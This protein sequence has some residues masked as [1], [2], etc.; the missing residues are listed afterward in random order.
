L[1][2]VILA[3]AGSYYGSDYEDT[4]LLA[5]VNGVPLVQS[6]IEWVSDINRDAYTNVLLLRE[7][8][9]RLCIRDIAMLAN[10]QIHIHEIDVETKGALCS[11]MLLS[12]HLVTGEPLLLLNANIAL[13]IPVSTITDYFSTG[14]GS[15]G[16]VT[17][18]SLHPRWSFVKTKSDLS[19]TEAAEKK[20][21]SRAA[22]VGIYWF[23]DSTE[24]LAYAE[25]V[26][27]KRLSVNGKFY[28]SL[29]LNEYILNSKLVMSMNL[30]SKSVIHI[31]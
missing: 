2:I 31:L 27:V 11:A 5:D 9:R 25:E 4:K 13:D 24:F 7:P 23:R 18:D 1:N 28:V 29:V 12:D 15:A 14:A 6:I 26:I 3:A 17:F 22:C 8:S 21:I 20:P 10:P 19:V 30:P 16:V